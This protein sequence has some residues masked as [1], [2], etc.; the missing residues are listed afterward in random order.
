MQK[1]L[2]LQKRGMTNVNPIESS[3]LNKHFSDGWKFIS[4]APFGVAS[5]GQNAG[6]GV[7]SFAAILVIIEKC[8]R[9]SKT[10]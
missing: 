9:R 4:A 7:D 1:A 2:I 3:E 10:A 6:C 8:E 5:A